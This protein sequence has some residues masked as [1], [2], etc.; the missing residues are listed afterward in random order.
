M[1]VVAIDIAD[2][3]R[4]TNIQFIRTDLTDKCL[5]LGLEGSFD[6]IYCRFILHC[7]PEDIEDHIL[8]S[9]YNLLNNNGLL[10][11]ETRSDK[12]NLLTCSG[13]HYRRLINSTGLSNKLIQLGFT[14]LYLGENDNWSVYNNNNPIL[15]RL[16]CKK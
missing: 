11:I 10:C 15:I 1:E 3:V 12:G 9:A 14:V 16:V 5:L 13:D 6:I 4:D 8:N 7:F 2:A